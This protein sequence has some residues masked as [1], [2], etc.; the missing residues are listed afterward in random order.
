LQLCQLKNWH[1][2]RLSE[3][4]LA[5]NE[6]HPHKSEF[7]M[8]S[9]C[10]SPK[11]VD[12]AGD[13]Q[14]RSHYFQTRRRVN[15]LINRYLSLEILSDRLKDLPSQFET[16]HQRPW[17]RINWQ[18]VHLSQIFDVEPG[19]FLSVVASAAEIET[20]IREYAQNVGN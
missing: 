16:P 3:F 17:E 8:H 14:H 5:N 11:I 12:L 2:L 1:K 15:C 18:E 9:S 10:L 6:I 19:L 20:P 7:G 13:R 4:Y